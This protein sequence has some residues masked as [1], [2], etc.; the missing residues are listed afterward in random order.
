MDWASNQSSVADSIDPLADWRDVLRSGVVGDVVVRPSSAVV[1]RRRFE[2]R[3]W[4]D[5]KM[6]SRFWSREISL[7]EIVS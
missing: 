2:R 5:V 1:V 3:V 7:G 6:E 4:K